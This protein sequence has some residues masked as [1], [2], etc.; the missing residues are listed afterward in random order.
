VE[1]AI[2]SCAKYNKINAVESAGG[3]CEMYI[4]GVHIFTCHNLK[5]PR[6]TLQRSLRCNL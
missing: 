2:C 3:Q 4:Q 5:K 6:V 1:R